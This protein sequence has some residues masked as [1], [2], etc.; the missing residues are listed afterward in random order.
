MVASHR[1]VDIRCGCLQFAKYD[2]SLVF[3]SFFSSVL[4]KHGFLVWLLVL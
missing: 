2:F 1:L 4:Q 3:D